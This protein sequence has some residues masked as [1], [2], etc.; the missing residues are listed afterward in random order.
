MA[1]SGPLKVVIATGEGWDSERPRTDVD[2]LECGHALTGAE[3]RIGRRYPARRRCWKCAKGQPPHIDA[4]TME[5]A[6]SWLSNLAP[7]GEE[8]SQGG[9][10]S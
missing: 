4:D 5:D 9:G 2:L 1:R 6:R 10:G 8:N 3:D 7:S